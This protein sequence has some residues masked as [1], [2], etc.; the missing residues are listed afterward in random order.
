MHYFAGIR[1]SAASTTLNPTS[2]TWGSSTLIQKVISEAKKLIFLFFLQKDLIL[3][4]FVRRHL[5]LSSSFK[6]QFILDRKEIEVHQKTFNQISILKYWCAGDRKVP[7]L[8]TLSKKGPQGLLK[9]LLCTCFVLPH[10]KMSS[11]FFSEDSQLRA[12][13]C[14]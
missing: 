1:C 7:F 2:Y 3:N 12:Y 11:L 10:P 14:M 13:L 8:P 4:L 6:L 9:P 5:Q